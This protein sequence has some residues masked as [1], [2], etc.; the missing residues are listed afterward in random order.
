M[1]FDIIIEVK[2]NCGIL[3]EDFVKEALLYALENQVIVKADFN[4]VEM[5]IYPFIPPKNSFDD[6]IKEYI[7]Y[8]YEMVK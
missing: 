7:E 5:E 8:Y 4:G 1:S 3:I 2:P 6:E